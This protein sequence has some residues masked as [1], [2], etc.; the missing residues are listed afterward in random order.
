[1]CLG[2]A[3]ERIEAGKSFGSSNRPALEGEWG[4][5]KVSAMTYGTFRADENKALPPGVAYS[6]QFEIR[7]GDLLI[8]RANTRDYVGASVL[9][10]ECPP[11]L[12]LS[13]KSLRLRPRSGLDSRWLWY[14][15]LQPASRAYMSNAS[16]GTKSGMRNI[17]QQ[18]IR[19]LPLLV[20]PIDEQR[21]IVDILEDHISRLDAADRYVS[22]GMQRLDGIAESTLRGFLA[23]SSNDRALG[24]LLEIPLSNGRSVPTRDDGFPV[25]RLTALKDRGVDL[26]E[27]K[28]GDWLRADARRFLVSRGDFLVARG[29]GSLRL[30]GRGSLVR[31]NPDEVAYPDTAIRV[32]TAREVMTPEYLDVVWNSTRT[33]VQIEGMARTTAGIYKVNQ[34][35]LAAVR[36]PAPSVAD[37]GRIVGRMAEIDE[38]AQRSRDALEQARVRA[39]VLRRAL[40]AAAFSGRLTGRHTDQ[41][42]IEELVDE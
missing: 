5:I 31:D 10:G 40:L 13:D 33:R 39:A 8:S 15:L 26:G 23:H 14:A 36:L 35:Q 25:L 34:K 2:D 38:Q 28:G 22:S 18:M 20:P 21:R 1:M 32:R 30:V 3:I 27:R 11:R 17:S 6:S 41:E 42:V 19:E 4:I 16:T 37:Q 7:P 9:V 29:N 12:L 24:E